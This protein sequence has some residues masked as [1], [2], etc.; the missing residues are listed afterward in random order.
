MD[1]DLLHKIFD[2]MKY[3]RVA[4]VVVLS[5]LALFLI[6]ETASVATN[7]GRPMNP[8]TDTITVNGTGEAT[9]P[10]DVANISFTV[11]N[12]AAAVSDAQAATTKQANAAIAFVKGQGV[13][14]KDITT[15]SYDI[16]PQYSYQNPCGGG[17]MCPI[18]SGS[19]KVTGYEVSET[20]QVTMHNL[21]AVGALLGGL[22]KLSVQNISG[23]D[24]ALDDPTAGYDAARANAITN[25]KTQASLLAKQLGINLG[26]IV[27][28]SES[29]GNYPTPVYSMSEGA[30][31][32]NAA[33]TPTVPAGENTYNAS[34]S[35]TYEIR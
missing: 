6:F 12:T 13:A 2:A 15:T 28:F 34:V 25:A 1:K 27:N 31:T 29:S 8:A 19:T 23:P 14:D 3:A 10:P 9:L 21:T 5:A 22:G 32:S 16:T 35:I 7:L 30:V 17:V 33:A 18:Y 20:I 26:K 11:Q 4:L 24:F